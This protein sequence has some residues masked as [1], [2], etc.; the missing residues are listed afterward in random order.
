MISNILPLIKHESKKLVARPTITTTILSHAIAK[1]SALSSAP[2]AISTTN[3]TSSIF[4]EDNYPFH[5]K[6]NIFFIINV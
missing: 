2:A 4:F 6:L 3:F 5:L 1:T